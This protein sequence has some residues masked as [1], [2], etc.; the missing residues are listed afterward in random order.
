VSNELVKNGG[1]F[2]IID[3]DCY[4]SN[5]LFGNVTSREETSLRSAK[6]STAYRSDSG[7]GEPIPLKV[8]MIDSRQ[9]PPPHQWRRLM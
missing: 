4:G 6:M 3:N 9:S 7:S 5:R 2:L 1:R 8:P